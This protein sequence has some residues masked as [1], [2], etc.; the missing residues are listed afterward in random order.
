MAH[1]TDK[2]TRVIRLCIVALVMAV[3]MTAGCKEQ[4]PSQTHFDT[5]K[6]ALTRL[7]ERPEGAFLIVEESESGRFVQFAG[8]RDEPL[9]LDLPLQTL[10]AEEVTKAKAVF[11]ELGY[12]GAIPAPGDSDAG[13]AAGGAWQSA[14]VPFDDDVDGAAKLAVAV[15]HRVYGFDE[16][17]KLELTEE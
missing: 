8:S 6:A 2:N 13:A 7:L 9:M 12:P 3:C 16:T 11:A 1:P 5:I 14:T 15:L 4:M 10:A 17:A